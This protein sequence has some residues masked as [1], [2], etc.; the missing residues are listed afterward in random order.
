MIKIA[1]LSNINMN[2]VIRSLENRVN[3]YE[4]EG[5]GSELGTLINPVSSYHSFH[6][7]FT[8]FIIDVMEL[9]EH[10]LEIAIAK[11]KIEHWFTMFESALKKE[12][13]YF[14]SDS[15]LWGV[16]LNVLFDR[17]Y[18]LYLEG[19]WRERLEACCQKNKNVH[20]FPIRNLIETL[21]E[22]NAFS[23]KTWY[24]GKIPYSMEAHKR[25][26][27]AI[28]HMVECATRVPK[29]VLVLD[30]DNT[31]WGGLAGEDDHAPIVLSEEHEGLNF[32]NLQRTILQMQKQ[33]VLLAIVSK[34]NEEDV[35]NLL[36]Q[37]PHMILRSNCF[38]AKRINWKPKHE[39]IQ[40]IARELNLSTD[41]FVFFDDNP[42]ERQLIRNMLPEVMVPDFPERPDKLALA[43]VGIYQEYFEKIT[44]TEEDLVK[45]EQYIANAKRNQL[46]E[47]H[48]SFEE[49]LDKL[50]IHLERRNPKDHMDRLLQL[51]NKTNQFNLTTRRYTY[52]DIVTLVH[53]VNKLVFLYNE[54]DCFG[55][56]GIVAALIVDLCDGIPIIE[57]F[58]MSC[59]VMGKNIE[60]AILTNMEISLREMGYHKVIGTF[61]PTAKNKPV[62][63]LY[64]QA[65]Y[66]RRMKLCGEENIGE[67]Y[68]LDLL[69]IPKRTYFVK[70]DSQNLN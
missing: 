11:E 36:D 52:E 9:L 47:S 48:I 5:Y 51:L 17:G 12:E 18:K 37:H 69:N 45:T 55:D 1:V 42:T 60:Y 23:L 24:L 46:R 27:D 64:E 16:E 44:M 68:E 25:L 67:Q 49:Y 29:K 62:S 35:I 26:S 28:I 10:N 2:Y 54:C 50:E 53:N 70:M 14:V 66:T 34:N 21:G 15:Y 65:G 38:A 32:K 8:F 6:P 43:M 3:V 63:K 57:N 30:L 56:N 59:R 31:L 39:N 41:S 58:V 33:G 4:V 40:E 19:L 22:E 20:I 7:Q 13:S 61:I